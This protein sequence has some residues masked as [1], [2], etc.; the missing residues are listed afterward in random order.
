MRLLLVED[1]E[2]I[3]ATLEKAL[4]E[5]HYVVDVATDGQA[6]LELVEAF[7]Y[8]LLLLDVMLPKLNGVRLCQ[9]LR[10]RGLKTPIIL[11]TAQDTSTN[12]IMG[13]DAGADDY[14]TKPFDLQELLARIRALLRRGD[15]TLPPILEWGN[16]HLDP[17]T[18]E[19]TYSAQ[20]IHLTP[21]EYGLLEL[22]LRNK[23]RVFSCGAIID[24]LWSFEGLPGEDTVRAHMK[25][26][27]QKLKAA[28]VPEDP[29]DTVY[30]IG[31]RLKSIA[32]QQIGR[33]GDKGSSGSPRSGDEGRRGQGDKETRGQLQSKIQNPPAGQ[34]PRTAKSKIESPELEQQTQ[35]MLARAW[36][37]VKEKFSDRVAVLE[38]ATTALLQ[39][40]LD[41][42]LRS[43]AEQEAHR[44][45]GSLGM[46]GFAEGSRLAQAMEQLFQAGKPLAQDQALQLS[47]LV[48]ALRRELQGTAMEPPHKLRSID[49]RPLLLIV[50]QDRSVAEQLAKAAAMQGMQAEIATSPAVARERLKLRSP[51]AVVL[52]FSFAETIEDNL[53][54]L[55]QLSACTPPVPVLILIA[56]DTLLDRVKVARLG[57]RGFL[58]QPVPPAQVLEAVSQVLQRSRTAAARILVVDDDPHILTALHTLLK[59]WG[60]KISTLDNPLEFWNTL[61]AGSPDLLIL[62]VEM[63]HISGIELCQVVRNDLRWSRLPVL[64]LTAH[65]DADTMR[66]VFAAGADDYVSKP[67]VGPELVTR[68]LN[69]LER[70]HLLRN[71]AETDA[72]TGVANRRKSTEE[73]IQFLYL[74]NRHS[75]PLCFAILA[76]GCL[77]QINN[78]YG[79]ATG[80]EVLSRLG[81]LLRQAFRSEDVIGRWGGAEFVVGMYGMARAEGMQRLSE[82]LETLHHE[83]FKGFNGNQ[84]RVSVS[85]GVSQ[86]PEAGTDLQTLYRAAD[87]ALR[88]AKA[89]GDH[90][91]CA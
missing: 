80:D 69:R 87:T 28:G 89:G 32:Q 8:D 23:Q 12:K 15:S 29:I 86:Y 63:P 88:Q 76:L 21:K 11:L 81:R 39:D 27:R 77:K 33:Q 55:A 43:R 19:V 74:A 67:I 44:L 41:D 66:R 79:Y 37:R 54:L 36:E 50:D 4:T 40:T 53:R 30:G 20:P 70:S 17:S 73:L 13:L 45:A 48:V 56:Q 14:M 46:F 60:L 91:A 18:C 84:F 90:V 38:Q 47:E 51:D 10:S 42:E 83:E 52:D 57:G 16:L 78:Q 65:T 58:Q 7:A 9:K 3:A 68:I 22:F 85:A 61:E 49:E 26:L 34:S 24:H 31:Y 72:L 82:V 2:L 25:G 59:P 62:D 35:A 6:G 75:Q 64:F 5:Q 71:M 1:D